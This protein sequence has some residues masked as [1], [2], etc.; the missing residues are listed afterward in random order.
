ML[1]VCDAVCPDKRQL[2]SNMSLSRNTTAERVDQLS[3]NLKEQLV[4]KGNDFVAY[5]LAVDESTDITD[6]AQLSIF[7]RGVDSTMSITEEFLAL[8]PMHGT[9]AN[10]ICMRRY[11]DV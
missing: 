7:I 3:S 10:K 6:I 1:K 4:E 9:T 5:S 11:P 2:F 8:R